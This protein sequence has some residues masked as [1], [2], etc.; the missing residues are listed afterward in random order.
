MPE[1][2]VRDMN[3]N[4]AGSISLPDE[5]FGIKDKD[6]LLHESVVSFLAN[7]R[8]GTHSTKTRSD[9]RGGGR[10]PYRQKGTGRSRAGTIRSPIWRGGGVVFGPHPRD[11]RQN[12]PRRARRLAFY[13]ALSA[14]IADGEVVVLDELNIEEPRTKRMVEIMRNLQVEGGSV[15]VVLSKMDSNVALSARNIPGVRIRVAADLNAYE[16]L[17]HRRVL[18]TKAAVDALAAGT[19][20]V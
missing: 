10:K 11:Y 4:S 1:L 3:N 14:R 8:Q 6:S 2:A 17:S 7:Q 13:A 9:V 12:M 15:L 18:F 20:E 5:F 16:I 19:R